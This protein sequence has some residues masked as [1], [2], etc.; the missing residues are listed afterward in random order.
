MQ[1][2]ETNYPD[3][4]PTSLNMLTIKSFA[5]E[6]IPTY[7]IIISFFARSYRRI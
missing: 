2:N 3:Q 5:T 6:I 4:N 1:L 7:N